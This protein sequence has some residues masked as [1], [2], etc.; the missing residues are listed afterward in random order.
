[1]IVASS[2]PSCNKSSLAG[3]RRAHDASRACHHTHQLPRLLQAATVG[4]KGSPPPPAGW[5]TLELPLE[6]LYSLQCAACNSRASTSTL[7]QPCPGLLASATQSTPHYSGSPQQHS[8]G[9]CLS[10]GPALVGPP[11]SASSPT[12]L[13]TRASRAWGLSASIPMVASS[14]RR[15]LCTRRLYSRS[16][17]ACSWLVV[18]CQKQT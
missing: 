12:S 18:G 2:A 7:T 15:S 9:A 3:R 14:L 4:S 16:L 1:M 8:H 6:A 17:S 13:A 10:V 11:A 5:P